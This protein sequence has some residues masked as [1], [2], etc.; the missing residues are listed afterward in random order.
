MLK[1]ISDFTA[2]TTPLAGTELLEI[3]TAGGDARKVTAQDIAD[4]AGGIADGSVTTAKIADAAVT[5][6]KMSAT[7]VAADTYTRA[8]ITVDAQGRITAA[9]S[10]TASAGDVVGP[11]S[12]TTDAIALFDGTT[13]KLI[14]D[15]ARTVASLRAPSVQTVAS[16]ATVTPTFSDDLVRI[17]AQAVNLTLANPSGTAIPGLGMVIRIK[18]NGTAQTISYG[19]QYRA[20]GV[21][22]P[23][24]TVANKTTYLACIWNDTDTRFDVVAVGTEA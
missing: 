21:T 11:A 6:A 22:L 1:R 5:S 12:A 24:T 14:K 7:G 17:T 23:T 2:A 19:T 16:A 3:E 18:D 4:L 13:G 8:T 9:S 10:N 20:I 15:S